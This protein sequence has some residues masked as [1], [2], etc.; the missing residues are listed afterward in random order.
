INRL[1][2]LTADEDIQTHV[3]RKQNS[4]RAVAYL[5]KVKDPADRALLYPRL[6]DGRLTTDDLATDVDG[7]LQLIKAEEAGQQSN[8]Q[9]EKSTASE[10]LSTHNPGNDKASATSAT[11]SLPSQP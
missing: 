6:E 11:P 7:L 4:L 5:I 9:S 1:R 3:R 8:G 2:L 10:N